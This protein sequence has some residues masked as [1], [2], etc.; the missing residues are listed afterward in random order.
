MRLTKSGH[1]N[2]GMQLF[3]R[4]K[5]RDLSKKTEVV[6]PFDG[7][8]IDTVPSASP[9]EITA[10]IDGL[11]KGKETMRNMP[12]HQRVEILR[13]TAVLMSERQEELGRLISTEEGKILAEGRIEAG[14]AAETIDLSADEARR[15]NGETLPLDSTPGGIGKLGFTL[16]IPCGIVAAITPFNFPLNLVAHKI[17]PAIA[18]GN[19][20]LLKPASDTPLSSLKLV[21]LLLEAGLPEEAI[22]CITGSGAALGQ[23]I[24][25][26]SRIRKISFTGSAEVGEQ[27]CRSAGLKRVTMEL[28]SNSPVIVLDDADPQKVAD[29]I[30]ITGFANAGQVC[31]SSQRILATARI[32]DNLVDALTARIKQLT[33]GNQ[34][35]EQTHVGP[36]VRERDA[37]R[38]EEWISQAQHNGA[39]LRC[40]GKRQGSVIQPAVLA[41]VTSE[42]RM[43]CE[44]LFGPAV[45]VSRTETIDEAIRLANDT[46]FG[47]SAAVFTQDIDKAIRFAREVDSGNLHINFGT[48]WRAEIMPYGGLKD[49]GV[50]KEGPRY[51]VE[52]MTETKMVVIH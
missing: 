48:A 29:A 26:D 52:E 46:R 3:L 17:G 47:L 1:D 23:S 24:C 5:W 40:G 20:V 27:I 16:R 44:E 19:A 14:R 6:N 45:G 18:A 15:L 25:S 9:T 39:Q 31:I 32:H 49:S 36:L 4:G 42:M 11:I 13:R 33:S 10:A 35:D 34:L 8:V 22:A 28:G 38:V 37:Q 7:S 43:S 12:S 51:A 2:R 21:E 30:A 41:N 50:G